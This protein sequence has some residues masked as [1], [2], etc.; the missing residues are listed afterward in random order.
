MVMTENLSPALPGPPA[1]HVHTLQTL[2]ILPRPWQSV[3][4]EG[5]WTQCTS[6][7]SPAK[8]QAS[9]EMHFRVTLEETSCSLSASAPCSS[10][11]H[12]SQHLARTA[13]KEKERSLPLC[14][15]Y[16]RRGD[17]PEKGQLVVRDQ[18]RVKT[19][20]WQ[21]VTRWLLEAAGSDQSQSLPGV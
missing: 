6:L 14:C 21:G 12:T 16:S 13:L 7:P 1:S 17:K 9:H 19:G 3:S 10:Q 8:I 4:P 18:R 15:L 11:S 2:R 5:A 20:T